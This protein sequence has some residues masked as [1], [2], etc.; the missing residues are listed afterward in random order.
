MKKEEYY[1]IYINKKIPK[2]KDNKN[3]N[4]YNGSIT[5]KFE[6]KAYILKENCA[7]KHCSQL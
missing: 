1:G 3:I 7:K 5:P 4:K 2:I 6:G